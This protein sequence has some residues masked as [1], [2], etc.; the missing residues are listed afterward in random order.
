MTLAPLPSFRNLFLALLNSPL[1]DNQMSAP[2]CRTGD[3][4]FWFS[5][6]A[7]SLAVIAQW[8]QKLKGSQSVTIWLPDFIC[9]SALIILRNMGVKFVFYPVTENSAPNIDICQELV[10]NNDI[11]LFVLVHYFGQPSNSVSEIASFCLSHGA[12]FIEDAT[13]VFLPV[14]GVGEIGDC[15]LYSPHKHLPVP[16]GAVLVVTSTGPSKLAKNEF[17]I[18]LLNN[19]V[20]EMLASS[21]SSNTSSILWL[22]KRLAQRFGIRRSLSPV[23]FNVDS[24]S[25]LSVQNYPR[26][27]YL[28]MRLLPILREEFSKVEELRLEN[29][30]AWNSLFSLIHSHELIANNYLKSTPYMASFGVRNIGEAEKIFSQTQ[31][32]GLPV[33][34]WP[35]LPPEVLSNTE[36]YNKA[37]YL[38]NTRLYLPVHQTL[39]K[40]KIFA[41]GKKHLK[42]DNFSW[43]LKVLSKEEWKVFWLN[44][45]HTNMLQSWQYG[46]AKEKAEGW[47]PK[48]YLVMDENDKPIA[49]V[50]VL[51]KVLPFIGGIARLNRGPLL[52]CEEAID[53]E[54]ELKL[55]ALN[56]LV[57]ESRK[58]HW[59]MFQVAPELPNTDFA[60]FGLK[61]LGFKKLT[62]PSWA[63]GMLSLKV[64]EQELLMS[65]NGKWRNTM[66]KGEKLGVIVSTYDSQGDEL[67]L[68]LKSYNNLQSNRHFEG[69]SDKL[70]KALACQNDSQWGFNFFIARD[71]TTSNDEDP[72]GMLVSIRSGD[73]SIYL[74]GLSTDKG[75]KMQVNS[76]LLWQAILHAKNSKCNWFDIGGLNESTPKGIA[77]F[78]KGLNATSYSLVGEWR[79]W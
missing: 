58:R 3:L 72:L 2:W 67:D 61:T 52:L 37:I 14:S 76:V 45:S 38:R 68:L 51:I 65:L 24:E 63:S 21:V 48:R 55:K 8:Q 64:D 27:S 57:K 17:A 22:V 18:N 50:Q 56:L 79:K 36:L 29:K 66:R 35:D 7:W 59:W 42:I 70:I 73:T 78:K 74:I 5:R 26:L 6:S 16:D 49:L 20:A 11:D 54:V 34:T 28:A 15:V 77:K 19:A 62:I 44:C 60:Q 39:S 10:S 40:S 43:N 32:A 9:N 13:H 25:N 4:A 46:D 47:R 71:K 75:R 53:K 41:Y 23:S 1:P 33:S 31:I 12:L 30:E 69:L